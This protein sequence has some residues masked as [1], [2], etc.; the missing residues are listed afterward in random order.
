MWKFDE[1]DYIKRVLSPAVDA[2]KS[3]SRL[4]DCFE[5]YDLPIT[6]SDPKEIETAITTVHAYWNKSKQ[7]PRFGKVLS[8]LLAPKEQQDARRNLLDS[9]ARKAVRELVEAE[10]KKSREKRFAALDRSIRMVASKGY[11]DPGELSVLLA[12]HRCE[13]LTEQEIRSRVRVPI[14]ESSVRLPTNEG[15]PKGTREQI[16]SGLNVLQKRDLYEF[17]GVDRGCSKDRLTES[18]RKRELEWRQKKSDFTLT[19]ANLLLGLIKTHMVDGD[20]A[21]YDAALA[22]EAVEVL[23]PEVRLAAGD[24]LITKA[25]FKQLLG[26]ALSH[27]L[28]QETAAEYILTLAREYG[29]AVE[30]STDEETV[31][32]AKCL[33]LVP[34]KTNAQSCTTCGAELWTTCPRCSSRAAASDPACAKCGFKTGD[35][36]RVRLL[37]RQAQLE[38]GEGRIEESHETAREAER[39]WERS[40]DVAKLLDRIEVAVEQVRGLRREIDE[41]VAARRFFAARTKLASLATVA[42]NYL[43]LDGKDL[44]QLKGEVEEKLKLCKGLLTKARECEQKGR[45]NEAVFAYQ[46]ALQIVADAEEA[47]RGLQRCPPEPAANVLAQ[48]H[49]GKVQVEWQPSPAVGGSEYIIVRREG[50]AA[51]SLA[52][53]DVVARVATTSC[54]DQRA[55]PASHVFYTVFTERTGVLSK[56]VSSAGMLVMQEVSNL[57]VEASGGLVNCSWEFDVPEG[58]VRVFRQESRPPSRAGDGLEIAPTGPHN[59]LDRGVSNGHLYYYRVVVEYRDAKGQPVFTSGIVRSVRPEQPPPAI[60]EFQ[61]TLEEGV[62]HVSWV[63]PKHG[64]VSFYR[65]FQKPEWRI[66][67]QIPAAKLAAL[68]VP[69]RIELNNLAVDF[70]PSTQPAFYVP[71]T[72]AGD[73]AVIGNARRYLTTQDVSHLKAVDFGRYLQLQ[74]RWPEDS[75]L[76]VVAWRHDAYPHDPLDAR[77]TTHRISRGEYDGEGGF[78]INDPAK[79]P[80][81]VVVFAV[82]QV[83]GEDIYSSGISPGAHDLL[84]T[85]LPLS[86]SYSISRGNWLHRNR[87]TITFNAEREA[88][89]LPEIVV[90]AKRGDIQPLPNNNGILL[91]TIS[92][93]SLH[94]GTPVSHEFTLDAVRR[95]C[96]LRAFFRDGPQA[97]TFRLI[98]P[99]PQ[100]LR[101]T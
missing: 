94:S 78:R 17:L 56:G 89:H 3:E 21:K 36:P 60:D 76:A 34:L 31:R 37:V 5:R 41:T 16:R 20:A 98:D 49:E 75:R 71:V 24:K 14:R 11:I 57:S 51:L 66:G 35:L 8:V 7:N 93:L 22:Y 84:R 50:R 29:A 26:V 101:I 38:L 74:W 32:C 9:E 65:T 100:Q 83:D 6:V 69:L 2:F 85:S 86:I 44:P 19:N 28:A 62:V 33:A 99:P 25:E 59:L 97:H 91:A 18:L 80:Y 68:G 47:Q 72:I 13:S 77:A 45:L 10:R 87:I 67:E 58:R 96:Y 63:P 55:R 12:Q 79:A 48:S 90:I 46:D 4:P 42:P 23:R 88:K 61:I 53:G 95:P 27:G 82:T 81:Y 92:D 70:A 64:A 40:G 54:L 52:D 39:L 73:V 43:G 30:W 15:L 1:A